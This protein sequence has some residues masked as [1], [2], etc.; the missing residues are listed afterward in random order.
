MEEMDKLTNEVSDYLHKRLQQYPFEL[1]F[2]GTLSELSA[3]YTGY[4]DG[5][6]SIYSF[7]FENIFR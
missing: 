7:I 2:T 6:F 5:C 4:K 3:Y 1:G